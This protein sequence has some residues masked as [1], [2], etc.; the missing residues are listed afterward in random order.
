MNIYTTIC[1]GGITR[2]GIDCSV[3]KH[4]ISHRFN[5]WRA[6]FK[7]CL[8]KGA[9]VHTE[10]IHNPDDF[11]WTHMYINTSCVSL[12]ASMYIQYVKVKKA[13]D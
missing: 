7:V 11:R 9:L 13:V 10:H 6:P 12:L 4:L 2:T 1:S 3:E 5:A 8:K